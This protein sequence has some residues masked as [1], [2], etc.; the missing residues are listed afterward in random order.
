ML[1]LRAAQVGYGARNTV[2]R[3]GGNKEDGGGYGN[4]AISTRWLHRDCRF[5]A[6]CHFLR[7]LFTEETPQ[8]CN[9]IYVTFPTIALMNYEG[10]FISAAVE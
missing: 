4:N 5:E 3:I 6:W 1:K 8:S 2:W 7:V 10:H 9:A